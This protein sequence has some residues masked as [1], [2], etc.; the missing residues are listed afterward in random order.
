MKQAFTLIE[1]LVV[2]LIIGILSAIALPQYERAVEKSRLAEGLITMRDIQ[3]TL[4]I[5]LL[6]GISGQVNASDIANTITPKYFYKEFDMCTT[7][8]YNFCRILI[9]RTGNKYQLSA[10]KGEDGASTSQWTKK[11]WTYQTAIGRN[12]CHSLEADGWE[13]NDSDF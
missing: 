1:L 6:N 3:N 7:E 13:Y 5:A 10:Q 11:C 4:D 2:V 9:T 8:P 12:I